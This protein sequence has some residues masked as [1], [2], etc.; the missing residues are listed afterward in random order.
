MPVREAHEIL[1]VDDNPADAT[2]V[3]EALARG[4]RRS[5]L[6]CVV[7]GD[8]PMAFLQRVTGAANLELIILDLNLPKKDGRAVL[9]EVKADP[10]LRRLPVVIFSTSQSSRDI[11]ASYEAGANCYVCKPGDLQGFF[12]AVRSIEDFWFGC[13]RVP[14]GGD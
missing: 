12:R 9:A 4:S 7:D 5:R 6:V 2:L 10:R 11:T 14:H 13:A 1:L 8:G 3:R